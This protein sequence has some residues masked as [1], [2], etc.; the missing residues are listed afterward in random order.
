[1]K[2]IRPWRIAA[3]LGLVVIL[4]MA[5]PAAIALARNVFTEEGMLASMPPKIKAEYETSKKRRSTLE[6]AIK[7]IDETLA[8]ESVPERQRDLL[9]NR[10]V[11]TQLRAQAAPTVA[12]NSYDKNRLNM[13]WWPVFYLFGLAMAVGARPPLRTKI[14]IG[15][16]VK[17]GALL[18]L[19]YTLP[20]WMRSFLM[21]SSSR[22]IYSF[23]NVD[24]DPY[25]FAYQE[26]EVLGLML[27]IAYTWVSWSAYDDEARPLSAPSQGMPSALER[28]CGPAFQAISRELSRWHIASLAVAALFSAT[29]AFYVGNIRFWQDPRYVPS[30]VILE[31]IGLITWYMVSRPLIHAWRAW[32][33]AR[34]EALAQLATGTSPTP[35]SI[36]DSV[37]LLD[38]AR[39]QSVWSVMVSGLVVSVSFAVPLIQM[40]AR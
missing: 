35:H 10:Q 31:G 17:T 40:L 22:T 38:Q 19:V 3:A 32:H 15:A 21:Q 34:E 13:L 14:P 20:H 36:E 6:D 5:I 27:F 4:T 30:A 29:L 26:I 7:R 23:V 39:P 28:S 16:V 1:M 18:Y 9:A 12:V 24:I 25:S 11:L 8:N 33:E 2:S 37:K